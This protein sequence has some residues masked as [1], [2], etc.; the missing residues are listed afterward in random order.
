MFRG[1]KIRPKLKNNTLISLIY[2]V[3]LEKLT[4][5]GVKK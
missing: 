2:S 5:L 1:T 4:F 3:V